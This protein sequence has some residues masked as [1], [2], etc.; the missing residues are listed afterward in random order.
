MLA[1]KITLCIVSILFL[2]I[3]NRL[4]FGYNCGFRTLADRIFNT[5]GIITGIAFCAMLVYE[6]HTLFVIPQIA[7]FVSVCML[8]RH[9]TRKKFCVPFWKTAK[10][11]IL[12]FVICGGAGC[13]IEMITLLHGTESEGAIGMIIGMAM[14]IIISLVVITNCIFG[15]ILNRRRVSSYYY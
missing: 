9:K 14:L 4:H 5:M 12:T 8:V 3:A 10:I 15:R 2:F 6:N 13:T 11:A 7:F 1:G